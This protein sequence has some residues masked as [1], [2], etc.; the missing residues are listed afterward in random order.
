VTN[1][2]LVWQLHWLF[3]ATMLLLLLKATSNTPHGVSFLPCVDT[4]GPQG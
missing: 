4:Q 3:V 1:A 2:I